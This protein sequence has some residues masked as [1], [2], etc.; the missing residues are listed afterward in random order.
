MTPFFVQNRT[1]KG[2]QDMRK[3]FFSDLF[4]EKYDGTYNGIILSSSKV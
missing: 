1:P 4:E 3:I 2:L